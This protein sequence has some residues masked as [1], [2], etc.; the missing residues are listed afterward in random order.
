MKYY[1]TNPIANH[2]IN[3]LYKIHSCYFS[4][5][6]CIANKYTNS[7]HFQSLFLFSFGCILLTL[8]LAQ[9]T[10][11][12]LGTG[13]AIYNDVRIAEA[14]NVVLAYVEGSLG[15]LLLVIAGVGAI[16]SAAFGQY[17]S[18]LGLLIVALGGFVLR[19]IIDTFYNDTNI[20]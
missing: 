8:G 17:R 1:M 16:L 11:A 20:R 5:K 3:F 4:L 7:A 10:F 12:N 2:I 19:S 15:A 6:T 14:T 18:A 9:E 13:R